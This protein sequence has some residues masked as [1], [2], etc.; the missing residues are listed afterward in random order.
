M[1]RVYDV[2]DPKVLADLVA[3]PSVYS[4]FDIADHTYYVVSDALLTVDPSI[5]NLLLSVN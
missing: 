1:A 5:V 3:D 4:Y 2:T